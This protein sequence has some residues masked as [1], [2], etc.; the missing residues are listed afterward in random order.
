MKVSAF[1]VLL[2]Q[3]SNNFYEILKPLLSSHL[4]TTQK[5]PVSISE[6][7]P[8]DKKHI[9]LINQNEVIRFIEGRLLKIYYMSNGLTFELC[10]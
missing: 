3:F 10:K 1:R 5:I 2:S 6:V 8:F 9:I 4:A 7:R